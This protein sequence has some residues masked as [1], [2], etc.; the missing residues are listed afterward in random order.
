MYHYNSCLKKNITVVV[1]VV[2]TVVIVV[3]YADRKEFS[4]DLSTVHFQFPLS[5]LLDGKG[6][7]IEAGAEPLL[8]LPPPASPYAINT[9]LSI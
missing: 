9:L 4:E 3:Q 2:I 6:D 1:L 5:N 7:G 8:N